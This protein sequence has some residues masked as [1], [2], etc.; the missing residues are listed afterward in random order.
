M[1]EEVWAPYERLDARDNDSPSSLQSESMKEDRLSFLDLVI[2]SLLDPVPM[3][4]YVLKKMLSTQYGLSISYGTLYPRLKSLEREGIL[5]DSK[6][7]GKYAA[8]N[9]GTNYEITPS[10][11]S[12]MYQQI[13][14]FQGALLR[15][16]LKKSVWKPQSETASVS[17]TVTGNSGY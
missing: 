13:Q 15:I 7:A 4:G 17:K 14:K 3:T 10:G 6:S 16:R 9:S 1:S 12:V 2:L 11:R 5:R 8:R